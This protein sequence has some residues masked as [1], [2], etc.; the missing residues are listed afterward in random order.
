[1]TL[2]PSGFT[3]QKRKT[4]ACKVFRMLTLEA[5]THATPHAAQAAIR[6]PFYQADELADSVDRVRVHVLSDFAR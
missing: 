3:I 1:L 4:I 2:A 5:S 6:F